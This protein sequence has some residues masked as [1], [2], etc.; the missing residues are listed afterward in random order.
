[1][2]GCIVQ[3]RMGSTRLPGKVMLPLDEEHTLL[4][5][6][7]KQLQS[8]KYIDKIIVATTD[9]KDDDVIV[10]FVT[11]MGIACFRGSDED[12]LDRYYQCAK[13]YSFST[14]VR[15]TSDCPLID[16]VVVD[17]LVEKFNS[18]SYDYVTN[19]RPLTFPYGIA[20]D[21]LSFQAIE[22]AWKNAKLPSEREHVTPYIVNNKQNF[23]IFNVTNS[24]NF[25]HIR[26]TVDRIN[27]LKLVQTIISKIKKRPILMND[28]VDLFLKEPELFDINKNYTYAEGYLKS[29]KE[30]EEFLK[31]RKANS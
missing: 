30:D 16:P 26:I 23:K 5:Y 24:Q 17:M 18:G 15:I 19:S 2:I 20:A 12:V 21:I 28:I 9:K 29:L 8:C 14:I 22:T 25:S 7:L 11:N 1:M 27:D 10:D 3:A 31:A 13:H 4:F 6:V